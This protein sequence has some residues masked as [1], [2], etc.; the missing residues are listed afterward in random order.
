MYLWYPVKG[1]QQSWSK[2]QNQ[3]TFSSSWSCTKRSREFV[4]A[5]KAQ[6]VCHSL[7][8]SPDSSYRVLEAQMTQKGKGNLWSQ[9]YQTQQLSGE[10]ETSS[11]LCLWVGQNI[12]GAS[13]EPSNPQQAVLWAV[14][15]KSEL[16]HCSQVN[17]HAR[18][19]TDPDCSFGSC[20]DSSA[21]APPTLC[22]PALLAHICLWA[23]P[24]H[25]TAVPLTPCLLPMWAARLRLPLRTPAQT[26]A[27]GRNSTSGEKMSSFSRHPLK[28]VSAV[29]MCRLV[30]CK[31]A[32]RLAR[33]TFMDC[34]RPLGTTPAL[35]LSSL[36]HVG[37]RSA[38][39]GGTV[40]HAE[41][42]WEPG[43]PF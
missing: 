24:L 27:G 11:L 7:L 31:L 4:G 23:S 1:P 41:V 6:Y 13:L 42:R 35:C 39:A 14:P 10:G 38:I 25:R 12:P 37:S 21:P 20:L 18:F 9:C 28:M 32:V 40:T 3:Q 5:E 16:K 15:A 29:F 34:S 19:S 36:T 2:F 8:F 22:L 33:E 17:S 30:K 43:S 26:S